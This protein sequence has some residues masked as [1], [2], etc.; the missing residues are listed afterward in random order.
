LSRAARAGR[1][2]AGLRAPAHAA[3][4]E[5]PFHDSISTRNLL[6]DGIAPG[7]AVAAAATLVDEFRD[8][9]TRSREKGSPRLFVTRLT[10]K[11]GDR[12][13][14]AVQGVSRGNWKGASGW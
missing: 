9:G 1:H 7:I 8:A 11:G 4:A 3:S 6:P 14:P 5:E 12:G 13:C 10:C 2:S